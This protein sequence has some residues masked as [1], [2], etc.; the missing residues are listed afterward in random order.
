MAP[1]HTDTDGWIVVD[2]PGNQCFGCGP[3]NPHG[4]RLR[5]RPV[6]AHTI[7]APY[8]ADEHL[9]GAP[10]IVHGGIQAVMLDEVMAMAV[11]TAYPDEHPTIVTADFRLEY[12]KPVPTGSEITI[13]ARWERQDGRS[14]FVRGEIEDA[15][16][17]L[18]TRAEARWVDL[19]A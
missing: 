19:D 1:H 13:R 3:D 2:I 17:Q 16:G 12:K 7:E 9:C 6:D 18:L 10:Q 4:L 15:E 11:Q 5:F 8:C 14:H